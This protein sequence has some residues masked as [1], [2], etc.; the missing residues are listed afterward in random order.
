LAEW[1]NAP[2]SKCGW[3]AIPS[4]VQILYPPLS[5]GVEK[6]CCIGNGTGGLPR[7]IFSSILYNAMIQERSGFALNLCIATIR[8]EKWC[9]VKI[10]PLPPFVDFFVLL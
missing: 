7:T 6:N 2:H 8:F 4:Q 1:S 3:G 5:Y 9:G 10:L